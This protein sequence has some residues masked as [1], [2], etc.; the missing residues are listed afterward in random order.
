M[1]YQEVSDVLIGKYLGNYANINLL[2]LLLCARADG[3]AL[4]ISS[5]FIPDLIYPTERN[6]LYLV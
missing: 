5:R 2:R 3:P 1:R 6:R 4:R